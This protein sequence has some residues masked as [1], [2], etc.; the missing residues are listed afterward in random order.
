MDA[1]HPIAGHPV[2]ARSLGVL[3]SVK[4]E[5][6]TG[7]VLWSL[8]TGLLWFLPARKLDA[9]R[10]R[11]DWRPSLD[12]EELHGEGTSAHVTAQRAEQRLSRMDDPLRTTRRCGDDVSGCRPIGHRR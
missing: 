12:S 9:D 8:A 1:A 7:T 2:D 10:R 4:N 11:S 6:L 3:A 5:N